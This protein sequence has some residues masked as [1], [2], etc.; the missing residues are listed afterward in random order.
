MQLD[1]IGIGGS[2]A[3]VDEDS[4]R[5]MASVVNGEIRYWFILS[6]GE[7]VRKFEF[8]GLRRTD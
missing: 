7:L 8:L 6:V 3:D 1:I 5:R 4:L 2:P